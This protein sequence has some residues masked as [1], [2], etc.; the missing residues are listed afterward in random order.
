[1]FRQFTSQATFIEQQQQQSAFKKNVL[2]T[3]RYTFSQPMEELWLN[4]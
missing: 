1:M 3:Y 2:S 4:K